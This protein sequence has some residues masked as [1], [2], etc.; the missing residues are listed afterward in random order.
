MGLGLHMGFADT[1]LVHDGRRQERMGEP[2]HVDDNRYSS[3]RARSVLLSGD[4]MARDSAD[5]RSGSTGIDQRK[6]GIIGYWVPRVELE[7][8]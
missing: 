4:A 1:T 5:F 2:A 3:F 8:V 6:D 7:F